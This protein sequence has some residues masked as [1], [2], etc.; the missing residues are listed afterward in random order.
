MG[1]AAAI[2][3]P[4]F[5]HPT[6]CID[7]LLFARIKGMANRADFHMDVATQGGTS[8]NGVAAT[9]GNSDRLIFRVNSRFHRLLNN[10]NQKLIFN[11]KKHSYFLQGISALFEHSNQ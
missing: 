8:L 1:L 4:E 9:T 7:D 5:I 2:L 10:I 6:G 11:S 3:A